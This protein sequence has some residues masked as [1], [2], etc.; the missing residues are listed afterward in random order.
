VLLTVG[1][2]AG[3]V[4]ID[5]PE[6]SAADSTA[7]EQFV[8]DLPETVAGQDPRE[9]SDDTAYGAAWGDP[10]IVVTCGVE[11]P[12]EF[13][14]FSACTEVSGVGWF[15]PPEQEEDQDADVL[16]TA[17][18]YS[19]RVSL[20]VPADRRGADS[21]DALVTVSEIVKKDLTLED[22]CA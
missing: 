17:V 11:V 3:P 2:S 6:L 8:A 5:A 13:D 22:D 18:G 21:A 16:L 10:A 19:P 4:E 12:E 1:C 9:L 15:V 20:L 14:Q 7:C